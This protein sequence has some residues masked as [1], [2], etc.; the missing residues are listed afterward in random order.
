MSFKPGKYLS[1]RHNSRTGKTFTIKGKSSSGDLILSEEELIQIVGRLKDSS[2]TP[3]KRLHGTLKTDFDTITKYIGLTYNTNS[4]PLLLNLINEQFEDNPEKVTPGT[5][6]AFFRGSNMKIGFDPVECSAL[7][8]GAIPNE[9]ADWKS[10][11]NTVIL[12]INNHN[13]YDFSLLKM[14]DDPSHAYVHVNHVNHDE[15]NGFSSEEKRKLKKYGIEYVYLHGYE[16]DAT[17]QHDLVGSATHIDDIKHRRCNNC[18]VDNSKSS[19]SFGWG[20]LLIFI[21]LIIIILLLI[22]A[23]W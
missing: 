20:A 17:K 5:I 4:Y 22:E 21:V 12:A 10:C 7:G 1:Q 18:G 13:G 11:K 9:D 3:L 2:H 16:D 6:G 14:G 15:F 23:F 19:G 8:A